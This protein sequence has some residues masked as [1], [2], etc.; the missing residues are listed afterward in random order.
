MALGRTV[1]A[2]LGPG[3]TAVT[4]SLTHHF[5]APAHA[6]DVLYAHGR[7]IRATQ[8]LVFIEGEIEREG[9]TIVHASGIWKRLRPRA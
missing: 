1:M 8:S 2:H 6:G 5:L 9:R 3:Q 7:I 4:A